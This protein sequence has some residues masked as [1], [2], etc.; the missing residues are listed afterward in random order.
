MAHAG[1]MASI[2]LYYRDPG[3]VACT[4][5]GKMAGGGPYRPRDRS[6]SHLIRISSTSKKSLAFG[7]MI[8]G[9]PRLP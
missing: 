8:G 7:G 2:H 5:G 6:E 1:Q 9:A 3:R 4:L